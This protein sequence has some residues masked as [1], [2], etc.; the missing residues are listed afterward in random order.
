MPT[1]A[2]LDT[3]ITYLVLAFAAVMGFSRGGIHTA[4]W[5]LLVTTC[6]RYYWRPFPLGIDKDL[7]RAMLI[8][9]GTLTLSAVFSGDVLASLR[10]LGL[11]AIKVMPVFVVMA[12]V[13]ERKV[14]ERAAILMAMSILVGA[15]TA[16]WQVMQGVGRGGVR[17]FLGVMDFGAIIGLIMPVLIVKALD[18]GTDNRLRFL[19]LAAAVLATVALVYNGTRAVWLAV[20]ATLVLYAIINIVINGRNSIKPVLIIGTILLAGALIFA[21]NDNINN[22]L[23]TI[24]DMNFRSN[25]E[26]LILWQYALDVFKD[27]PV[28]GVG[29]ATLPTTHA[30]TA[31]EVR[32]LQGKPVYGH[33][34]NTILQVMAENGIIGLLGFLTLFL[35]IAKTALTRLRE[36]KTRSWALIALLC[37]VDFIIHGL[38]DYTFTIATVMYS[39]WFI[40]GLAYVDIK[41]C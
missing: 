37:T 11:S 33:V 35:T 10:F 8:F 3:A 25:Q 32:Q 38:F 15:G 13:K 20:F 27:H 28:L 5:L 6:I 17:S 2:L 39:Y 12:V 31:E 1:I 9:F 18:R 40:I 7:K 21:T 41:C 19:F 26:R 16:F 29:L 30:F 22:R 36:Q 4:F 34:H 24:T 23:R 14:I